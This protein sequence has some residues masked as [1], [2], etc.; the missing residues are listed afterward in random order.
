MPTACPAWL[1]SALFASLVCLASLATPARALTID[2]GD[3]VDYANALRQTAFE[4]NS[5]DY[6]T[7]S[8]N[9][10]DDFRS[11]AEALRDHDLV[12]A[13]Y[14]ADQIDY[15][16][17][18][19]TDLPSGQVYHG[20][21]EPLVNG[22]PTRGWGSYFV[23][24]DSALGDLIAVPHPKFDTNTPLIA[25]ETFRLSATRFYLQAGAHR[26]ANGLNTADVADPIGSIFQEVHEVFTVR[27]NNPQAPGRKQWQVHGF[28][29]SNYDDVSD[30]AIFPQ[31][32]DAVL[33]NGDGGV[34]TEV[35]ALEAQLEA[36]GF[37][38]YAYNT[39]NINDPLNQL[40][41]DLG[42]N[43]VN[44]TLFSP[45]G[46]TLNVQGVFTR[47]VG[48]VFVHAEFEQSIRF[49][50][51][52]RSLAAQ[53]LANAMLAT[54]PEPTTLIPLTVGLILAPCRRAYASRA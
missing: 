24:Y 14:W 8:Q 53:A 44:G 2:S 48:G 35:V 1:K 15:D 26:S 54:I 12:A 38:I 46:G 28:A 21:V 19:F 51:T 25:S 50:R 22:E 17:V 6:V 27:P 29:L 42:G 5:F 18:Q 33:T 32:T 43:P 47:G 36:L 34:S 39:L 4:K 31:P 9:H 7:P 52:H 37:D 20:V 16:L 40:V 23:N 13:Q 3:F 41:N 45:L 30:D 11:L 49:N 10:R